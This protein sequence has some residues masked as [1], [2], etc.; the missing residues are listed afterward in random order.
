MKF[1]VTGSAGFIGS[2]CV[3]HLLRD[4]HEVIGVDNLSTG[5]SQFLEG[6]RANPRFRFSQ[7]DLTDPKALDDLLQGNIDWVIHLAANADVRE[8]LN[9]PSKDI[10]QNIQVTL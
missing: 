9:H 10:E 1:L 2:H 3:D 5:R 8:G 6:A 4:G 7:K